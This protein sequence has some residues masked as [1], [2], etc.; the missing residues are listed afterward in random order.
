MRPLKGPNPTLSGAFAQLLRDWLQQERNP[1][2]ELLAELERLR[3]LQRVTLSAWMGWLQRAARTQR[4]PAFGLGIGALADHRHFGLLAHLP[5]YTST[6][7]EALAD[8]LRFEGLQYGATWGRLVDGPDGIGISWVRPSDIDPLV[9]IVGLSS[10]C[11]YTRRHYSDRVG[12]KKIQFTFPRPEDTSAYDDFFG[13][14][15]EFGHK[16]LQLIFE[17]E[18]EISSPK[19][20]DEILRQRLHE[21]AS[22]ALNIS[23]PANDLVC[24][25]V[26]FMQDSLPEGGAVLE[27]FAA[28]RGVTTRTIQ[29][30]LSESGLD[31]RT[32][33]TS[34]RQN[35]SLYFLED[36]SLTL[37]EVAF[38][39]GYSEQSAFNHAFSG[40]FGA[41][42]NSYRD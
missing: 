27:R 26:D 2:P 32:I 10:L 36:Q 35:A 29:K 17:R 23:A 12:L 25:L 4:S 13:C 14:Q 37:A 40:W 38:L 8:Y 19:P 7:A 34:V 22:N 30:R 21:L 11:A 41:S 5:R 18:K 3:P 6:V 1:D 28:Q 24:E 15:V 33:L 16:N 39:L 31:F 42:P 9:E 20:R